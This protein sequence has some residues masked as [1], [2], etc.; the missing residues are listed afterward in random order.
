MQKTVDFVLNFA[1]NCR[2]CAKFCREMW[3]FHRKLFFTSKKITFFAD[4]V[5]LPKNRTYWDISVK[6]SIYRCILERDLKFLAHFRQQFA[7]FSLW[8]RFFI[9]FQ[10]RFD[11]SRSQFCYF[12]VFCYRNLSFWFV[13]VQKLSYSRFSR[14]CLSHLCEPY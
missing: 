7:F 4:F 13:F 1:E 9:I 11:F 6:K 5:F 8:I 14:I 3:V 12:A 2:F 10:R